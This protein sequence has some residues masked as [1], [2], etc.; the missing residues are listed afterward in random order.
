MKPAVERPRS[1]DAWPPTRPV[2]LFDGVCH[3]CQRTVQFVVRRERAPELLFC[4]LQSEAGKRLLREG[5]LET[6]YRDSLVVWERGRVLTASDAALAIARRL[7]APW[8]WAGV[9]CVLPRNWR[10]A[11]YAL[12]ARRRYRW[13]G[14][15]DA[16]CPLP[17]AAARARVLGDPPAFTT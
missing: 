4:P 17:D 13:F 9:L 7:R 12:I 6:D 15:D 3:L 2:L 1:E 8:R 16:V 5:G 10:D 14:R 11:V